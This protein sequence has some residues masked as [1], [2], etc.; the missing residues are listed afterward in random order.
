MPGVG[1]EGPR[2]PISLDPNEL[3]AL[4]RDLREFDNDLKKE[5]RNRWRDAARPAQS[6]ARMRIRQPYVYSG[7][8]SIA[9]DAGTTKSGKVKKRQAK[10]WR[11]GQKTTRYKGHSKRAASG[12][13]AGADQSGPFL[14]M[15][16]T[17]IPYLGW[18]EFGGTLQPSGGRR[19]RQVRAKTRK[20]FGRFAYPAMFQRRP[21]VQR[22][23][24]LAVDEVIAKFHS[25]NPT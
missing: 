1:G 19:G 3:R 16:R 2:A 23:A 6:E 20:G 17:Q 15:K 18:L 13:V 24:L 8:D 4:F 11:P 21:D 5:L 10:S 9:S 14:H 7:R 12:L 22:R 25:N